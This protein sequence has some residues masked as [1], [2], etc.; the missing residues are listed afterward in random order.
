MRLYRILGAGWA[1]TQADAK[2]AAKDAGAPWHEF[3]VP[4][5]KPGLLAF[6]SDRNV[7]AQPDERAKVDALRVPLERDPLDAPAATPATPA[8]V[9]A[10]PAAVARRE[11]AF[12]AD[13]IVEFI[14]DRAS[15]A[16]VEA[17]FAAIGTR[18]A[19]ARKAAA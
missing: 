5:D 15:V 6:L 9:A 11:R 4:T 3:D 8:A 13:A 17:I 16:Q 7:P 10:D 1:G 12:E 19:E 18:F 14:L 2:A